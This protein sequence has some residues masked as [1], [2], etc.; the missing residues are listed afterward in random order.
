MIDPNTVMLTILDADSWAPNI[1][2]DVLEEKI[3]Q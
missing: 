3:L 2:F 1:Y